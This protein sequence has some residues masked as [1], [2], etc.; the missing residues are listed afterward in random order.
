MMGAG[1]EEN[2]VHLHPFLDNIFL[3]RTVLGGQ[4]VC[5]CQFRVTEST[6]DPY[7]G[8]SLG[9]YRHKAAHRGAHQFAA[10]I[11]QD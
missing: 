1:A 3:T 2:H 10:V 11:R 7:F 9:L 6:E 8:H 4:A 5:L